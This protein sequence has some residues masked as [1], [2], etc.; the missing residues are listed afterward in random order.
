MNNE[1]SSSNTPDEP[2]ATAPAPV[3]S[4]E[5]GEQPAARKE[6]KPRRGFMKRRRPQRPRRSEGGEARSVASDADGGEAPADAEVAPRRR[7]EGVQPDSTEPDDLPVYAKGTAIGLD[8][9]ESRRRSTGAT[10]GRPY[11]DDL[12]KLHKVLA[13]SGIGSRRDM[14]ELILAGRVSV[15]GQPAHV[16]QRIGPT[17]QVR[18]NGRPIAQRAVN[19]P[20]RVLLYHKPAGEIVSRDDPKERPAVFDKLPRIKGARWVAVGRLD[21]N[22]EGLLVF[23]TSGDI[24]NKL[25]HPRY[26]WEREYAVRVLGRVGDEARERLLA[27]VQ[28]EDGPASF[29][30]IEE[31]GGDG[32]NCWYRV[33]ISEGRNREVRRMFE[34]VDA[35]VSRLVR[36]RFG[37]IALPR[38]L[39]R[40]RWIELGAAD[41]SA[42]SQ[43]LRGPDDGRSKGKSGVSRQPGRGGNIAPA[44]R[45]ERQPKSLQPVD[46]RL[47]LDQWPEQEPAPHLLDDE[48]QPASH[49]AHMEGISRAV[50]KGDGTGAAKPQPRRRSGPPRPAGHGALK[51][52]WQPRKRFSS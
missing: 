49:D 50:R 35:T 38:G 10:R 2:A 19:S 26:G 48:W 14:E 51:T 29:S 46:P 13:D 28:L 43:A 12:P 16:G 39:R 34:A 5:G 40:G 36:I 23:T 24:A 9:N 32:A 52:A 1:S 20:P 47:P 42:L 31:I 3:A 27:G 22:T 4:A 33:V 45:A 41:L 44:P 25:M 6:G 8:A 15:N 21:F 7:S 18:V 37:P 17:D 11:E 30:S